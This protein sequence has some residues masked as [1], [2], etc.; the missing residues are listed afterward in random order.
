MT[1]QTFLNLTAGVPEPTLPDTSIVPLTVTSPVERISSGTEPVTVKTTPVPKVKL[2]K[3]Y[4]PLGRVAVS[5]P[6]ADHAPSSPV[7]IPDSAP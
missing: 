5:P 4:S 3:L 2:E 1:L 7:P 6:T